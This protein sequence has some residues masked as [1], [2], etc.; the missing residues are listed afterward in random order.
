MLILLSIFGQAFII[1]LSGAMMPGPFLT[2]TISETSRRGFIAGPMLIIG[3]SILELALLLA[4]FLGLSPL[5]KKELTILIISLAG[6]GILLWMALD[7]FRS[8]PTLT[9]S[10]KV[11]EIGKH[12]LLIW[13]GILVSLSNPYW[14]IWWATIGLNLILD[15]SQSGLLG[16]GFFYFGHIMSD[17]I[18]YLFVTIAV[19]KGRHFLNNRVYRSLIG[20]CAVFLIFF[21]IKF[22]HSGIKEILG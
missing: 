20:F 14:S 6:G 2:T 9:L 7:M 21:A 1:G 17:I 15:S 10:L 18:W 22:I 5:F 4:L 12:H 3:H 8:L 16:I 11:K 13:T 19:S